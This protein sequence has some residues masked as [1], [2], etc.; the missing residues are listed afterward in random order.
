MTEKEI[1]AKIMKYLNG[2]LDVVC[3]VTNAE[4]TWNREGFIGRSKVKKGWPDISGVV[5]V[6][7]NGHNLGVGLF[8]EVKREGGTLKAEQREHLTK[9]SG[10]GAICIVARTV[11]E[12][13]KVVGAFANKPYTQEKLILVNDILRIHL[14]ERRTKKNRELIDAKLSELAHHHN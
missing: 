11:D 3:S 13:R 6:L 4:R 12:V 1:Q 5:S 7:V 10:S 8:I 2:E 9:L 14:Y